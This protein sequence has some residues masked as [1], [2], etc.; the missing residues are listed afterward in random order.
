[1]PDT[2]VECAPKHVPDVPTTA[3]V[4]VVIPAKNEEKNL[5]GILQALPPWLHE[6]ILVDGL[7]SDGTSEVARQHLDGIKI[8]SQKGRGKGDALREG[9][10]E[11]TG[12]LVIAIDADGSMDPAEMATFVAFLESGFDYVKGSR[13]IAGGSSHDLTPFRRFGNWFFRTLT[14]VLYMSRYSDLCYGYFAFRRGTVDSLDLRSDGF[15]IETEISIKAHRAGFRTAEIPSTELP[16]CNGTSNLRAVR[17]G[18]RILLTILRPRTS[19][20]RQ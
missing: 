1:L 14:N 13:M 18:W 20:A 5:P 7:S 11:C 3:R 17:D 16:R 8:V 15:E 6:V 19:R 10:A 2:V 12:D 4:S 9:F